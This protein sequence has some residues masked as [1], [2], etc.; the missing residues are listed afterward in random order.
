M[1]VPRIPLDETKRLRALTTLCLLDTLPEEKFDRITR[2][3]SRTFNVP[4]ALVSLVDRDR[5]WFKSKQGLDTCETSR[6]IS[7]CGH[8]ILHDYPLI[9]PDTFLNPDF[10]DNPLVTG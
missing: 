1:Q 4:I 10:A 8:A 2:L 7:F 9:I 6:K 5:Q 3:A